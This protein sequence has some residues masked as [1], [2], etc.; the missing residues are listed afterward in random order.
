[1]LRAIALFTAAATAFVCRSADA[2]LWETKAELDARYGKP[3]RTYND[4]DGKH[5][6][7]RF[8]QYQVQVMLLDGKSQIE[9]YHHINNSG[10]TPTEI[11]MFLSL[12]ALGN[13][14]RVTEEGMFALVKPSGGDPIAV[15][16]YVPGA[17]PPSLSV[18]TADFAKKAGLPPVRRLPD[19]EQASPAR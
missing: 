3:T 2:R 17:S 16:M 8:K 6:I 14:W 5:Y 11:Q 15:G 18:L 12:N 7:Y 10:L 9:L 1:M 19:T 4:A 13:S